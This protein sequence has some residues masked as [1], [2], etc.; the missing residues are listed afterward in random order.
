MLIAVLMTLASCSIKSLHPIYDEESLISNENVIGKWIGYEGSTYTI[1]P[2]FGVNSKLFGKSKNLPPSVDNLGK[3]CYLLEI[4]AKNDT[5]GANVYMHLASIGDKVFW[6]VFPANDYDD[7]IHEFL[8]GNLLP[9]H[10]FGILEIRNDSLMAAPFN[11][12]WLE[13]LFDK[14]QI[15]IPHE[16]VTMPSGSVIVLTASTRELQKFIVK[17]QNEP[18]AF[19]GGMVLSRIRD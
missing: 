10:T 15:R 5:I 1:E 9:V 12:D 3:Q 4:K 6:D 2:V 17:Y 13:D 14:N 7:Y 16:K 19:E 8:V 11:S 18:K